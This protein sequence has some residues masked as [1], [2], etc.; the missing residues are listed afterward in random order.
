[1]VSIAERSALAKEVKYFKK[2]QIYVKISSLG[3]ELHLSNSELLPSFEFSMPFKIVDSD[4]YVSFAATLI[5]KTKDGSI[6]YV[7]D[8]KTNSFW[9][10]SS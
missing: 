9:T 2:N 10:S 5:E 7:L 4:T 1:M 3:K 8:C 6:P